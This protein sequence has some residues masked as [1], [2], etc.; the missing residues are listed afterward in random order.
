M[1]SV[2]YTD[3]NVLL[4]DRTGPV[5]RQTMSVLNMLGFKSFADVQ[6]LEA[7]RQILAN[8][9]MDVAILAL[10]AADCGVLK[11]IDDIRHRRSGLDPFLPILLTAWDARLKSVRLVIDSGVDDM[12][13]HPFS[14]N[15]MRARIE[16]LI[17]A[18]KPFVVTEDYFGPDR[19]ASSGIQADPSSIIVP[20]A[21][22]ARTRNHRDAAPSSEN[23]Q[24][25]FSGLRRLKLRNMAR[26]IWYLINCLKEALPEPTL[27]HRYEDELTKVRGSIRKYEKALLPED[28]KN[29]AAL[30]ESL[31]GA[32]AKL[33]GLP[34][35]A[36]G[37][38]LLEKRALALRVA[39]KL[40]NEQSDSG[41]VIRGEKVVKINNVGGDL[42]QAVMG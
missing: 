33:F 14:I 2:D 35:D 38:E 18:R 16:A 37:L 27:I 13:L 19:R 1:Q 7:A 20:N 28:D 10:E 36:E 32:L 22:L 26:R 5:L 11:L 3:A 24:A 6:E 15:Q 31:S 9:R 42:V 30:C 41:D 39:S 12:L 29:L 23:I 4:F 34:P 40:D 25:A 17:N 8:Q 21:L